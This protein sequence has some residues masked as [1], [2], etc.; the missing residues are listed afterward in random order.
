MRARLNALPKLLPQYLARPTLVQQPFRLLQPTFQL[1]QV[2]RVPHG[3]HPLLSHLVFYLT[4]R[5]MT[6]DQHLTK[7][8]DLV[9]LSRHAGADAPA[10]CDQS[11]ASTPRLDIVQIVRNDSRLELSN[12]PVPKIDRFIETR[13]LCFSGKSCIISSAGLRAEAIDLSTQALAFSS[14]FIHIR[15]PERDGRF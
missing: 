6:E 14:R 2:P 8:F 15:G 3:I 5:C 10:K 9:S 7:A 12:V 4:A 1:V 13:T 11:R